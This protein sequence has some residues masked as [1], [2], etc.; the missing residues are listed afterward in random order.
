MKKSAV[1][2]M[3]LSRIKQLASGGEECAERTD[4]LKK[5]STEHQSRHKKPGSSWLKRKEEIGRPSDEL[6]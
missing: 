5:E 2:D 6:W 3:P 4:F 1:Y